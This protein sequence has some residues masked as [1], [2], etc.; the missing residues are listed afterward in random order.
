MSTTTEIRALFAERV[1]GIYTRTDGT[2]YPYGYDVITL[3]DDLHIGVYR[4]D[5]G[6]I[7]EL[8]LLKNDGTWAGPSASIYPPTCDYISHRREG[9]PY[10]IKSAHVGSSSAS[11]ESLAHA[12]AQAQMINLACDYAEALNREMHNQLQ[13]EADERNER[14]AE[15]QAER[16]RAREERK[17]RAEARERLMTRQLLVGQKGRAKGRVGTIA[18]EPGKLVIGG[19]GASLKVYTFDLG[20]PDLTLEV[21]AAPNSR[22]SDDVFAGAE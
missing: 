19:V 21:K 4:E 5:D 9:G 14:D 11:M 16:D 12:R 17:V 2:T 7:R 18:L 15:L 13:A 20:D 1:E 8:H 22:F 3:Q 10:G 6:L